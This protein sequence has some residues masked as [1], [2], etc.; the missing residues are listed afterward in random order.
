MSIGSGKSPLSLQESQLLQILQQ[1]SALRAKAKGTPDSDETENTKAGQNLPPD[2]KAGGTDVQALDNMDPE[3]S[4]EK[5]SALLLALQTQQASLDTTLLLGSSSAGANGK[6]LVDY[7]TANNNI[8]YPLMDDDV[9][10]DG[11]AEGEGSLS[12]VDYLS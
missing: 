6:T 11:S 8:A 2:G 4:P 9:E 7:L 1:Q 3:L 10:D 12:L 5:I